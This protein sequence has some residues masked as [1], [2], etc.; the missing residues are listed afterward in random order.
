MLGVDVS[1]NVC[2]NERV[3][4]KQESEYKM[5]FKETIKAVRTE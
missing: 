2:N 1:N 4:N 5:S 3:E